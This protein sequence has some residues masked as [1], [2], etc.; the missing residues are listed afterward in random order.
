MGTCYISLT[1]VHVWEISQ[2]GSNWEI[3]RHSRARLFTQGA[4]QI[5]I[6]ENEKCI[7]KNTDTLLSLGCCFSCSE[8][9]QCFDNSKHLGVLY[10]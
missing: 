5:I 4:E 8:K 9:P 6:K 3:A 2:L 10:Y 1:P 7:V